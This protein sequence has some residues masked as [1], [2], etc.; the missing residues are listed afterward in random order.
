MSYLI[1]ELD[2]LPRDSKSLQAKINQKRY[3]KKRRRRMIYIGLV[4]VLALA[5]LYVTV[6]ISLIIVAWISGVVFVASLARIILTR[7]S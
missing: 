5:V 7:R 4:L 6:G 2:E 3:E 1:L